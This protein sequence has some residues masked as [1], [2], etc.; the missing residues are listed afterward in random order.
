MAEFSPKRQPP[1]P[2]PEVNWGLEVM[3]VFG[4]IGKVMLRLL[5]YVMNILLTILL[6]GLIT[7]IIVGT[8]FAI[9][10]NNY[11]DLTVDPSLLKTSESG[12]T[13]TRFYVMEFDSEEDRINRN[14]TPVE[15]EDERI[16]GASGSIWVSYDQ[17]PK[18]L[19]DAFIAIEDHRFETHNGVDWITTGKAVFSYFTGSS[20]AGGSTITQ[21]LIKNLT[22]EDEVTIT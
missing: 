11:L 15:W 19:I 9:Y 7:G 3:H 6:I 13:T 2:K 14:G 1:A 17:F 20:V 4:I 22:G 10:I 5:S 16:S 8:V 21:Q 12:T 18:Y